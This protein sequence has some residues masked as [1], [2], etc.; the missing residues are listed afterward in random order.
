MSPLDDTDDFDIEGYKAKKQETFEEVVIKKILAYFNIS[1]RIA[2]LK[3]AC[4][5][6]T[7]NANLNWDW[8]A[9]AYSTFPVRIL[10]R[11]IPYVHQVSVSDLFNRFTKTIVFSY[12]EKAIEIFNIN[13]AEESVAMVFNWPKIGFSMAFHNYVSD[14]DISETRFIRKLN[15]GTPVTFTL[16]KF[17]SLL[18]V[19]ATNWST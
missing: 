15:F 9:E 19:I 7:G 5:E 17:S 3:Q 18:A 12:F 6:I 10:P 16:E 2:T 8:F 14:H 13:P 11:S 4:R 1:D